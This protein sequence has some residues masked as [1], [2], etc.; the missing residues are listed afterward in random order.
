MRKR[1]ELAHRFCQIFERDVDLLFR[2]AAR[3]REV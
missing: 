2:W 1:S 3:L